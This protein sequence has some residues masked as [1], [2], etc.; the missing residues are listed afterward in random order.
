MHSSGGCVTSQ[1][2]HLEHVRHVP[3]ADSII[4][5]LNIRKRHAR[6]NAI[7][8]PAKIEITGV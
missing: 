4:E 7:G 2:V 3:N 8:V 1:H 5:S 6:Y